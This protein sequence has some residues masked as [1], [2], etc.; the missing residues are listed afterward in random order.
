[1]GGGGGG[2][3]MGVAGEAGGGR[4]GTR[5]A[6][7][8][9]NGTEGIGVCQSGRTNVAGWRVEGRQTQRR[10]H[11]DGGSGGCGRAAKTSSGGGGGGCALRGAAARY[12]RSTPPPAAIERGVSRGRR[13]RG[14]TVV[15]TPPGDR[16]PNGGHRKQ[17]GGHLSLLQWLSNRLRLRCACHRPNKLHPRKYKTKKSNSRRGFFLHKRNERQ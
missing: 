15:R 10:G 9:S 11:S 6:Q 7:A 1:M 5:A 4:A 2:G 16:G 8:S 14:S 12:R 3:W 13:M 17:M